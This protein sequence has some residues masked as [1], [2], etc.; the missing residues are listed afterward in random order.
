MDSPTAPRSVVPR[1]QAVTVDDL[2]PVGNSA[3][4]EFRVGTLFGIDGPKGD[5]EGNPGVNLELLLAHS[6][7]N[8]RIPS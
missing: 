6:A 3:F 8:I 1:V 5:K 7:Q 4:D 2:P